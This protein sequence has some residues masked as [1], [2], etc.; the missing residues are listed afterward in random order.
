[1]K[2]EIF[3]RYELFNDIENVFKNIFLRNIERKFSRISPVFPSVLLERAAAAV[4]RVLREEIIS[5]IR[6]I[7]RI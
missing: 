1:M 5:C 6:G 3:T 2:F 4:A 7:V